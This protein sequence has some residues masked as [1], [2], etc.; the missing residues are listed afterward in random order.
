MPIVPRTDGPAVGP[1]ALPQARFD[2]PNMPDV[3]SAQMRQFGQGMEQAG[4]AAAQ[5][6]TD[7]QNEANQLR[8]IDA[9]NQARERMYDLVYHPE[10]GILA[11]KGI[12]ALER[13]DGND[14]ATEYVNRF[15]EQTARI[16]ST[17]GNDVQKQ[18]FAQDAADMQAQIF[19]TAERHMGTEFTTYKTGTY[20]GAIRSQQRA[21]ALMG[22]TGTDQIDPV[23]LRSRIDDAAEEIRAAVG[24]KARLHGLPQTLADQEAI[25]Q[26]SG[27]HR[28]AFAAA[29]Q[30]GKIGYAESYLKKY[31]R[32]MTPEH[33]LAAQSV[34]TKEMDARAAIGAATEAV[35]SVVPRIQVGEVD[36]AFNIA[37]G[38][39]SGGQQFGKDG[40]PLTSPKGAIGIAQV[41]P[42]TG[43]EAAKLAGLPWDEN[44]YRTDPEYNK[45]LGRAYFQKQ[46]HDFGGDLE[47][48][49]AAYNAGPGAVRAALKNADKPVMIDA[50]TDPNAPK[51]IGRLS[52]LPPETQKYVAKNMAAFNSG[53]G[54]PPRPTL[55]EVHGAVVERLGPD[56]SPTRRK[57]ALEE[58]SR[59]FEEQAKAIKQR[60]EDAVASA[61]RAVIQNGGRFSDLP[62][63]VRG[64]IPPKEVDNV[65]AFAQKISKGDDT[66]SLF[67][68]GQLTNNPQMLAKMSDSEF[69][70]LR[71]ELS[72]SDFKH[73][74][75]ERA[76]LTGAVQ[77]S[78]GPGDLNT[79]AIK[80]ALDERLRMLQIDPSPKDDGKA[81]AA[82]IGG[83]RHFVDQYMAAAQREAG[84]KFSDA[85]VAQHLD[86]L[87][88]KNTTFRGWFS[89]KSAPTLGL[90]ASDI[91]SASKNS[92]KDAFKR[93]GVDS[94]TD[95]QIMNAY[96]NMKFSRRLNAGDGVT[97]R[98]SAQPPENKGVR[99]ALT[100]ARE[101]S[102][103]VADTPATLPVRLG[104]LAIDILGQK[105]KTT[106]E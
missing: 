20:D 76:K 99:G 11:Q 105:H 92:I 103:F 98:R 90:T 27:A 22:A 69:F 71:R 1:N 68:Y 44:R 57:L 10:A 35:R 3:A 18:L 96:W 8:R 28:E 29:I 83:I 60:E 95:A 31:S 89:D 23:T 85:E 74:S 104:S 106:K 43:P 62:A 30:A 73:F 61:M 70:A 46:V 81:D 80:Q 75:Q 17:L 2:A 5:I 52:F 64:S 72:E 86:A 34:I 19:S 14:L 78:N 97:P 7:V 82:R 36:R 4:H 54:I 16:S 94:P 49:Y 77:G 79:G 39:E 84:K 91:D 101:L 47:L 38:T 40:K 26:I 87:F 6:V 32:E 45:A 58:A 21:I 93:R 102:A 55:A 42:G 41:M 25:V 65:M 24:A 51:R 53:G 100:T 33:T 63:S 67:R 48:A 88:A 15:K 13:P 12:N 9:R 66:T 37:I 50:S 56:A 59:Q